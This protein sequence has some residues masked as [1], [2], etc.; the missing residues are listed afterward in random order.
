MRLM[1]V[2]QPISARIVQRREKSNYFL[3]IIVVERRPLDPA[4][5]GKNAFY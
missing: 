5:V 2:Q 3:L 4:P 1:L